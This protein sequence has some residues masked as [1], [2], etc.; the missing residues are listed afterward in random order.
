MI[1]FRQTLQQKCT[2]IAQAAVGPASALPQKVVYFDNHLHDV[3]VTQMPY[4]VVNV[5]TS[6]P[7]SSEIGQSYS[8]GSWTVH[9]YYLDIAKTYNDGEAKRDKIMGALEKAL[10]ENRLLGNCRST[11]LD[12]HSEYVYDSRITAVLFDSSGQ[13]EYYSFISE[14]YLDVDTGRS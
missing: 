9:F 7:S 2:E 11:A 14:L 1:D 10:E 3:E 8:V 12:G 6:Q 5:R 13:E 4:L